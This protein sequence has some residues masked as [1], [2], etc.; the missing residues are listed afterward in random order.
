MIEV[1]LSLL[2]E[3]IDLFQSFQ[4]PYRWWKEESEDHIH[5]IGESRTAFLMEAHEIDHHVRLVVAYR[6]GDIAFVDDTQR[7]GGIGRATSYFL[8][9]GDT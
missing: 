6:D 7:H 1:T 8:D 2:D 5:I 9:I 3:G 4:V